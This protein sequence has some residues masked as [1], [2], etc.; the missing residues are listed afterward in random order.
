[1]WLVLCSKMWSILK[2]VPY[3]LEMNVWLLLTHLCLG[4][5]LRLADYEDQPWPQCISCLAGGDHMKQNLLLQGLVPPFAYATCKA[6]W[7]LLWCC[8]RL[9]TGCVGSGAPWKKLWCRPCQTLPV[10]GPGKSLATYKAIHSLW[11]SLLGLG[12]CGKDQA[13]HKGQT[14]PAPGP[15]TG[16]E[17]SQGTQRFASACLYVPPSAG[18]LLGSVTETVFGSTWVAWGRFSV[19][20]Q[21]EVNGVHQIGIGADLVLVLCLRLLS[22]CSKVYEVQLSPTGCLQ[23]FVVGWYL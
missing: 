13:V 23:S 7:I 1:M 8:L 17:N 14:L 19:T 15:G 11:L 2:N 5:T 12:V 10:N 3:A 18:C 20:H 9:A 16:Q 6:N 4:L 22:K 21:T